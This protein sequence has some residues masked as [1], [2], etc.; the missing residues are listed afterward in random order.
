MTPAHQVML[1]RENHPLAEAGASLETQREA[2]HR[3]QQALTNLW[4]RS[5]ALQDEY[6]DGFWEEDEGFWCFCEYAPEGHKSGTV[7]FL[8]KCSFGDGQILGW[9]CPSCRK[10]ARVKVSHGRSYQGDYGS[11][12]AYE[13]WTRIETECC[14]VEPVLP[15]GTTGNLE[16][17]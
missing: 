10:P 6:P 15:N 5:Q 16:D 9:M 3:R 14:E 13:S 8:A 7:A 12:P 1:V 11:V 4:Q 2:L 17:A